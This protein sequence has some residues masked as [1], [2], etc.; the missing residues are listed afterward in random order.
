MAARLY[1]KACP[2]KSS[3]SADD[4]AEVWDDFRDWCLGVLSFPSQ[5]TYAEWRAS[6][7]NLPPTAATLCR[8]LGATWMSLSQPLWN[9]VREAVANG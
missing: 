7:F 5:S 3:Y 9:Q 8:A 1:L 2:Q 4:A 6:R